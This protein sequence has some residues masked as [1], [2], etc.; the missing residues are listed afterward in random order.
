MACNSCNRAICCCEDEVPVVVVEPAGSQDCASLDPTC[1]DC[2]I[3]TSDCCNL[4][5]FESEASGKSFVLSIGGQ[6][7]QPPPSALTGFQVSNPTGLCAG[8]GACCDVLAPQVITGIGSKV[9]MPEPLPM[10]TYQVF[11]RATLFSLLPNSQPTPTNGGGVINPGAKATI[12]W[13][14]DCNNLINPLEIAGWMKPCCCPGTTN[15][16]DVPPTPG[17]PGVGVWPLSGIAFEVA[18]MT[19]F[20]MVYSPGCRPAFEL[21]A[22][23]GCP[24]A[25]GPDTTL[26]IANI[27]IV[28]LRLSSRDLVTCCR[29]PLVSLTPYDL[30]QGCFAG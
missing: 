6:P 24:P 11:A 1:E 28:M 16:S 8:G 22:I 12:R 30:L 29:T 5:D 3:D 2:D 17:P 23:N 7:I 15:L 19:G 9:C 4:L 14:E 20:T 26:F 21:K 18:H 25:T 27:Q 13:F 10:G